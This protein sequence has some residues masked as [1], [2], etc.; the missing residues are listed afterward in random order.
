[1]GAVTSPPPRTDP[2]PSN[3]PLLGALLSTQAATGRPVVTVA[4]RALTADEL[5]SRAAGY[6]HRLTGLGPVAVLAEPTVDTVIAVVAALMA[7]VP[8]VPVP[9]DAGTTEIAH[10]VRDSGATAVAGN[11]PLPG[12]PLPVVREPAV[13]GEPAPPP[14]PRP[15][16]T[17]LIVYT[18]G[19][20]GSPK[21]AVLSRSAVAAGLDA[22]A[23]AWGWTSD[24]TLVHGLPL[25]HVHGL[26]LGVLGALRVGSPLVHTGTADPTSYAA[27]SGSLYFGVPTIWSRLLRRRPDPANLRAARLLVS[28]SAA[29]PVPV[30]EGLHDFTGHRP[31][32]RYGMS[33]TLITVS[34]PLGERRPGWVGLPLPGVQTRLVD[35]AGHPVSPGAEP[36]ELCVRGPMLFDGYLGRPEA[37]AAV[38][39]ADGWMRTGDI[40]IVDGD[41]HRIVGRASTD[42]ISSGGYRIGAGEVEDALLAHPG[43]A[44]AAV[45]GLP[46]SDLGER[47]VAFVVADGVSEAELL[48]FTR[49]RLAVHKRPRSIVHRSALPRNAMGKIVKAAL[50]EA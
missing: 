7:G 10:L 47:V 29:L 35:D 41:W 48:E 32:E 40:A 44:E 28:G 23:T 39:D 46:D 25:F 30:F 26:I 31:V 43:V 34:N 13:S 49:T 45:L 12:L 36:A 50:R 16:S 11:R 22:L 24:D 9:P 3:R 1:M 14:E 27:T 15:A 33:E 38:L 19:T 8:V 18:S 5:R 17:A 42:L 4:G 20:T 2:C 21:G 6:A 37:T